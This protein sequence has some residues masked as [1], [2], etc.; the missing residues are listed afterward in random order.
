MK[1]RVLILSILFLI[2]IFTG[3]AVKLIAGQSDY[4]K[5]DKALCAKYIDLSQKALDTNDLYSAKLYAQKAVQSDPWSKSAWNNYNR[6]IIKI[7]GGNTNITL[8][9]KKKKVELPTEAPS[10]EDEGA[11]EGC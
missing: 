7:S 6:I 2:F 10:S 8:E 9:P 5:M 3:G 1:R 11:I 4:Y